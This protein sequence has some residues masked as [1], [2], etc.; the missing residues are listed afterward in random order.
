MLGYPTHSIIRPSGLPFAVG[1]KP[2]D[3]LPLCIPELPDVYPVHRILRPLAIVQLAVG[4]QSL[5][6]INN[7]ICCTRNRREYMAA[8]ADGIRRKLTAENAHVRHSFR[9][10]RSFSAP[11]GFLI[12][13]IDPSPIA[14]L[15]FRIIGRETAAHAWPWKPTVTGGN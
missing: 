7:P 12:S 14:R 9:I 4:I 13:E 2:L 5:G 15:I 10:L 11:I 1:I 8:E 6:L 3:T